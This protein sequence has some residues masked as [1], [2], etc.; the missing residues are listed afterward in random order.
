LKWQIPYFVI[1]FE[2]GNL[3]LALEQICVKA[4]MI[5]TEA[6]VGWF[7]SSDNA[8]MRQTLNALKLNARR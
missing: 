5:V 6:A 4:Q 2:Y 3:S 8:I 7:K 1:P